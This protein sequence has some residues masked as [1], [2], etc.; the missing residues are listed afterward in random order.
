MTVLSGR[1]LAPADMDIAVRMMSNGQAHRATP[2][3]AALCLAVATRVPGSIPN[4]MAKRRIGEVRARSASV[5]P[6]A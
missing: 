5:M 2:L 3:T 1:T 6:R 4:E